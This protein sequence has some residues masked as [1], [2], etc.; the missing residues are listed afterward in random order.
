MLFNF[1]REKKS[2]CVGP[3]LYYGLACI[4]LGYSFNK[5]LSV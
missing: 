3:G 2:A 1:K 4:G 5:W